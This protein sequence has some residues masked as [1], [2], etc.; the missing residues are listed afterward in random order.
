MP[1]KQMVKNPV[2][3]SLSNEDIF[4][5][6][7]DIASNQL[8][9]RTIIVPSTCNINV[10]QMTNFLK[11]AQQ[12][13]PALLGSNIGGKQ[14]LGKNHFVEVGSF[15]NNKIYFCNMY[16]DKNRRS[17]RKIN[18]LA[19]F[20]CMNEIR[21]I[22]LNLKHKQDRSV[23]IHCQKDALGIGSRSGGRWSTVSDMIAD[24]WNGIKVTVHE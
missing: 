7:R 20:N 18:Y 10:T 9:E 4:D 22:C 21:N 6:I 17:N 5:N 1:S 3:Y 13:F 24:C 14:Q 19:L 11:T 23:E 15:K 12:I 2:G 8:Y 16:T